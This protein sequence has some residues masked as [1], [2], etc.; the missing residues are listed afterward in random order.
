DLLPGWFSLGTAI[1][2]IGLI[3]WSELARLWK[4]QAAPKSCC[5]SKDSDPCT[6]AHDTCCDKHQ[7]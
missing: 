3:L 6:P 7:T 2:L 1:L 5:T 4:K